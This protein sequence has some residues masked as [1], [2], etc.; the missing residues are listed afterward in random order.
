MDYVAE[1]T[2]PTDTNE[3]RPMLKI[4]EAKAYITEAQ[5]IS[6]INGRSQRRTW[7]ADASA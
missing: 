7:G 2:I 5:I 1:A 3:H 6:L 4:K